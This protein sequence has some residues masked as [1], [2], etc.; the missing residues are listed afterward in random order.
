V[1]CSCILINTNLQQVQTTPGQLAPRRIPSKSLVEFKKLEFQSRKSINR[2]Y[3]QIYAGVE[4]DAKDVYTDIEILRPSTLSSNQTTQEIIADKVT[5]DGAVVRSVAAVLPSSST[6]SKHHY[7]IT[8]DYSDGV[9]S[10]GFCVD[11]THER[12]TGIEFGAL[13]ALPSVNSKF[14][15]VT[16]SGPLP[17]PPKRFDVLVKSFWSL[18]PRAD[19]SIDSAWV[20]M[21]EGPLPGLPAYEVRSYSNFCQV[22]ILEVPSDLDA[23]QSASNP[24]VGQSLS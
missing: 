14:Y 12:Q 23:F 3:E 15:G 4:V 21:T 9:V 16:D 10:W 5:M 13:R 17:P 6:E 1:S 18:I 24:V 7:R 19:C 8:E 11:D 22:V 20:S 2:A